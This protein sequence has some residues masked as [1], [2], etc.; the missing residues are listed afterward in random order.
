MFDHRCDDARALA[1]TLGAAQITQADACV[2][3]AAQVYAQTL[4]GAEAAMKNRDPSSALA[5]LEILLARDPKNPELVLKT[6][7]IACEARQADKAQRYVP[8]IY[9]LKTRA[10]VIEQC[11]QLGVTVNE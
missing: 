8:Q 7:L 1:A 3:R 5:I 2:P 11:R 10:F 6:G 9:P 4:A